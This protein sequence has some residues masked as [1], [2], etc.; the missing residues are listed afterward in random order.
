MYVGVVGTL[1]SW[2]GGPLMRA[3]MTSRTESGAEYFVAGLYLSFVA[4][5]GT[6]GLLLFESSRLLA[7][8]RLVYERYAKHR[9][10]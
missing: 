1:L 10:A 4:G 5:I 3:F 6:L 9:S 7:F 8:E 2:F